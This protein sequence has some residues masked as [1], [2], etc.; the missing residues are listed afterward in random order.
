MNMVKILFILFTLT[1]PSTL[2]AQV[3]ISGTA[4]NYTD[5]IFYISQA[6]GFDN[7]TRFWRDTRIKV[8]INSNHH[9]SVTIPENGIGSWMLE[10]KINNQV[11]DLISGESLTLEADFSKKYPLHAVGKNADDFNYSNYT[12]EKIVSYYN[13]SYINKIRGRDIDSVLKYRK[14]LA[15]FKTQLLNEYKSKHKISDRYYQ[16]LVSDYRYEPYERTMVENLLSSDSVDIITRTKIMALGTDDEY[17]AMNTPGYNDLVDFYI[18]NMAREK[19]NGSLS[20]SDLFN[21]VA[22]SK[23]I[24][25]NTKNV[26]LTR[27]MCLLRMSPAS[28]YTPLLRKYNS[29]VTNSQMRRQVSLARSEYGNGS[30]RGANYSR[31]KSIRDILNKYKGKVIYVDFWASWCVPCR[32]QM[33]NAE[34]LRKRLNGKNVVFVYLGYEDK[35]TAWLKARRQLQIEGEH[36]LLSNK[37]V[38]EAEELFGIDGIPHYAIINKEG[39][40]INKNAG[41]PAEVY[42][43]LLWL[44]GK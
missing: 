23:I 8:K 7:F 32:A 26:F 14:E 5:P 13:V 18:R 44:S 4:K 40:I 1:L 21:Y 25:G 29:V 42:N 34:A 10:G 24:K 16:W 31:A 30:E 41:R 37:L 22:N 3:S 43:I 15:G 39:K 6:G 9:F 28:T 35:E 20:G 17:A 2:T 11:F 38:K 19:Y 33:P 27:I 12:L 36:Y